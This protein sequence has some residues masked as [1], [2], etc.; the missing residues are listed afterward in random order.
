MWPVKGSSVIKPTSRRSL[1]DSD[2]DTTSRLSSRACHSPGLSFIIY[3]PKVWYLAEVHLFWCWSHHG[4]DGSTIK[5]YFQKHPSHF[6][7]SS[8]CKN[9]TFCFARARLSIGKTFCKTGIQRKVIKFK[10]GNAGIVLSI[11]SYHLMH[12]ASEKDFKSIKE[13]GKCTGAC[14][15]W[16]VIRAQ[17]RRCQNKNSCLPDVLQVV[18]VKS[19][20]LLLQLL[21]RFLNITIYI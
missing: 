13:G 6:A 14:L 19:S 18:V 5:F 15:G 8:F 9:K 16:Q 21:P 7:T 3:K 20:L 1:I 2:R 4:H 17:T 12:Q 10:E 11:N